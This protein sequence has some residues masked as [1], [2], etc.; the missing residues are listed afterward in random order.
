M[1]KAA[2]E[3]ERVSIIAGVAD[4]T[5]KDQF[6]IKGSDM[7]LIWRYHIEPTLPANV[8][9]IFSHSP[10][11]DAY[12][13]II[14]LNDAQSILTIAVYGDAEDVTTRF[15]KKTLERY[16]NW[17]LQNNKVILRGIPR[18]ITAQVSG[19][20]VR[21]CLM[22]GDFT[23]FCSMMPLHLE[24]DVIWEILHGRNDELKFRSSL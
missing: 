14:A 19:T 13:T 2:E 12:D 21:N 9:V 24:L 11:H 1:C 8:G 17:S 7:E 23:A 15:Q 3:C 20:R 22:K 5:R 4:R 16:A 6:I 18:T 10:L